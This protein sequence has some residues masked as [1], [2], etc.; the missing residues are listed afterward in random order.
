[1]ICHLININDNIII[2]VLRRKMMTMMVVMSQEIRHLLYCKELVM[3]LRAAGRHLK[4][5]ATPPQ[6]L[7]PPS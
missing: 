6:H 4:E 1:M 2:I 5:I 7:T 3:H